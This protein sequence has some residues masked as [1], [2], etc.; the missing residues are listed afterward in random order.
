MPVVI[1]ATCILESILQSIFAC[2]SKRRVTNVVGKTK[3]FGQ[4]FVEAK[5]AGNCAPNLGYLEAMGKANPEM[6]SIGCHE[7]L[8]FV[9]QPPKGDR[10][11]DAIAI[12][13]EGC[14]RTAGIA[15]RLEMLAAPAR[16]GVASIRRPSSHRLATLA[17][18]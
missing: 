1:E 4:V 14:S 8:R 3:G 2:M 11:N 5:G 10:M 12:A 16:G 17:I 15:Q 6:V 13:L 7:N 18:S 9:A